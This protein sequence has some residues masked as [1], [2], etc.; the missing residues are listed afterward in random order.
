MPEPV[1]TPSPPS[2]ETTS[3]VSGDAPARAPLDPAGYV[4]PPQQQRGPAIE[5]KGLCKQYGRLVAI[6]Q[7]SF[8]VE[9]G[10]IVGFL[11]PNGAGKS[12]TM[13]VLTGLLTADAGT[14]H[15]AGSP[16]A[17]EP[18]A[19]QRKI[20]FMSEHNPLPEDLRVDEYLRLRAKL[21]GLRGRRLRQRE[22]EV[23]RLTDLDP[24]TGRKLIGS[25]SKGYRQRV[26]IADALLAEPEIVIM[27]EPTIGLD[28]HQIRAMR[29]LIRSLRG[30]MSVILS[31]HILPEIEACCD[32]VVIINQG[33]IVA[34]GTPAE[35]RQAFIPQQR[36][37][38]CTD[39]SVPHLEAL[40]LKCSEAVTILES[41]KPSEDGFAT[42]LLA[43]PQACE[44]LETLV[45][46]L[47]A[48]GRRVREAALLDPT[49]E[50]VFVAA[51]E[52]SSFRDAN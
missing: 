27:D 46:G 23:K 9:V 50:D 8:R 42:H 5:V 26:G 30:R 7:L 43:A 47:Q 44:A 49:L 17:S 39:A 20:G 12:T 10:E 3:A 28:P 36:Y 14:A 15:V 25:L 22:E 1:I 29:T 51:T 38:V 11:G 31:S 16:V 21:K 13:R 35:L 52:R 45:N 37:R 48:D 34:C 2:L 24:K 32:R 4:A 19:V 41:G 6:D 33:R 40:C 18:L